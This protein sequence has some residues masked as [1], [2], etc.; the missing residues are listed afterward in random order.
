MATAGRSQQTKTA[1][2]G[3]SNIT[4][5]QGIENQ[6]GQLANSEMNLSGGLSPLVSKQLAS[7]SGQIGKA[8]SGQAQAAQ[9][10]LS[11]RGMGVAPSGLSA[12][13][14]NTGVNNAGQA[15]TGAIGNAFG[16]Q[17]QLNNQALNPEIAANQATSGDISTSTGANTALSQMPSTFGNIMSGL[18][19]LSG[20]GANLGTMGGYQG[21]KGL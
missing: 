5:G 8:Y 10:G 21:I 20:I 4:N 11:Q 13:I 19:G 7:E 6:A 1:S 9:R 15:Q 17:N 18:S 16:T 2:S 3:L 14:A 12:S